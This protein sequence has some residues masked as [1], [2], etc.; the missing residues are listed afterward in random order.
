MFNNSKNQK[1][2]IWNYKDL[3]IEIKLVLYITKYKYIEFLWKIDT[4][5][6][7]CYNENI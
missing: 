1:L 5:Y 2:L 4:F 6:A 3:L 7:I